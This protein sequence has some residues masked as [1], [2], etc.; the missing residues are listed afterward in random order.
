MIQKTESTAKLIQLLDKYASNSNIGPVIDAW[1]Q[2]LCEPTRELSIQVTELYTPELS[3]RLRTMIEKHIVESLQRSPSALYSVMLAHLDNRT[4]FL[5]DLLGYSFSPDAPPQFKDI[6]ITSFQK[7]TFSLLLTFATLVLNQIT[8]GQSSAM[9]FL[10]S[11]KK[12]LDID[13]AAGLK[14]I[15]PGHFSAVSV[16]ILPFTNFSCRL[17]VLSCLSTVYLKCKTATEEYIGSISTETD[18]VW[19]SQLTMLS[20]LP[21][22][23]DKFFEAIQTLVFEFLNNLLNILPETSMLGIAIIRFCSSR[24]SLEPQWYALV[25]RCIKTTSLAKE[26]RPTL[27][28]WISEGAT[29][30]MPSSLISLFSHVIAL[31][32]QT[33]DRIVIAQLS[34]YLSTSSKR[35]VCISILEAFANL[36][37]SLILDFLTDIVSCFRSP[38]YF[39]KGIL[40]LER[41]RKRLKES[42]IRGR[43]EI[44]FSAKVKS[45]LLKMG[46]DLGSSF[47]DTVYSVL[48]AI[49]SS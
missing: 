25:Q 41:I 34:A 16:S 11:V 8:E 18:L 22:V 44:W 38:I 30:D 5:D 43:G 26:I 12:W 2:R 15:T 33:P 3:H 48:M 46:Q 20:S 32:Q 47:D 13:L 45:H 31:Q 28:R 29:G 14:I 10:E 4:T 39:D 27:K 24:S 23:G 49:S 40:L 17:A 9:Y 37:P 21:K 6:I 35:D 36:D 7:G 42:P 19:S 1:E